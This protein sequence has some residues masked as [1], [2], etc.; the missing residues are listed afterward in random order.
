MTPAHARPSG[1]APLRLLGRLTGRDL[2]IAR[3]LADHD[4]L[5]TSQVADLAFG[6]VRA[7]QQRLRALHAH[8]VTGRFRRTLLA[9][10]EQWKHYL[11][12][13]GAAL[14]A[15]ER[16]LP[17][18]APGAVERRA[19]TL[20]ASQRLGHLLGVNGF[21]ASLAGAVHAGDGTGA[22]A[23]WW[24]ERRCA[25][26]FGGIV[27]PDG[28]GEWACGGHVTAFCAEFDNGT[29][30]GARVA[31][32][33]AGYADLATAQG[34]GV[35]VLLWLPSPAR[36]AALRPVLARALPGGVSVATATPAHGRPAGPV[37]LPV[38][39]SRR[40]PLADIP[41]AAAWGRG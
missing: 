13:A 33:L 28:Y 41:P 21:F 38:G 2:F 12:P 35:L 40:V 6:S 18:P 16:G 5:T 39:L 27:R 17:A 20:A 34:S 37:W 32:K 19:L 10:S 29:E 11:A 36:E 24:S 14:I 22:L 8:G 1:A 3:T 30:T 7:A 15:A 26:E 4:V 23:E 25:A 31:G 9:G